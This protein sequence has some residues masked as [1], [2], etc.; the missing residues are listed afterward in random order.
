MSAALTRTAV[1]LALLAPV[2]CASPHTATTAPRTAPPVVFGM[3][4]AWGQTSEAVAGVRIRVHKPFPV[5][6]VTLSPVPSAA[7]QDATRELVVKIEVFNSSR[8]TVRLGVAGY[9]GNYEA[10][11]KVE[12]QP[13]AFPADTT[14]AVHRKVRM[15]V[16]QGPAVIHVGATVD[17]RPL[18]NGWRYVGPVG[19]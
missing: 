13:P 11:P 5:P 8:G 6:D 1:L 19:L 4:Y 15:P 9:V 2:A 3:G 10:T 12:E 16:G 17:R 7:W 18:L 14:G